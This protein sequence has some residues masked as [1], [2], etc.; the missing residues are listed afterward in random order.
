M[1]KVIY[2]YQRSSLSLLIFLFISSCNTSQ[3]Y[4]LVGNWPNLS[5]NNVLGQVT[6][7]GVNS[8]NQIIVF[9]RADRGWMDPMP[10]EK[11]KLPTIYIFDS[12]TGSLANSWGNN[13]FIMPHGLSVDSDDNIWVTDVGSHEVKKFSSNGKLLLTLGEYMISNNDQNHFARPTDVAF[14]S[15]GDVYISDGYWNTRVVK[16][17]KEGNYILEWG[18][19]GDQ[20]GEFNLPHGIA[21]DSKDRIY[22]AD[23]SNS[24][25][26]VFSSNGTFISELK[27]DDLGR[28]FGLAVLNHRIYLIDGGDQPDKTRSS[29]VIIPIGYDEIEK[30]FD[31]TLRQDRQNLGHDIAV[32]L[33][34]SIYVADAWAKTIRKYQ[35]K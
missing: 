24:R 33:D 20:P 26:Q 11:I 27:G 6:G 28:P 34:Q 3:S 15:K 10:D 35:L 17:S 16:Y 4:T 32:G 9:H 13:E 1:S 25:I 19:P 30:T 8:D 2:F 29:V 12:E 14:D 7:V 18:K 22:V 23:R 21:I 31:A 5:H